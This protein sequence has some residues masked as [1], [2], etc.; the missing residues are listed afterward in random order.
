MST[1]TGVAKWQRVIEIRD[2][3]KDLRIVILK[4]T[5]SCWR[6]LD[7]GFAHDVLDLF[8]EEPTWFLVRLLSRRSEDDILLNMAE[9]EGR[10]G[11]PSLAL[12]HLVSIPRIG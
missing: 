1:E 5:K 4:N 12:V 8:Y 9:M 11:W 7:I 3:D 2:K 10:S 6:S